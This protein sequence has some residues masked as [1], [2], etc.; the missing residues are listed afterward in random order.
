MAALALGAAPAYA[1]DTFS[2]PVYL[3]DNG[4]TPLS[5]GQIIESLGTLDIFFGDDIKL[6]DSKFPPNYSYIN[7]IE[8]YLSI[9]FN[10]NELVTQNNFPN[11][12]PSSGAFFYATLEETNE[13][14]GG[15][16][17]FDTDVLRI[18]FPSDM[19]FGFGSPALCAG[20]GA[21]VFT[22]REGAVTTTTGQVN[23]EIKLVLY[24][25]S[26][27]GS[28]N[29]EHP[30][31][32]TPS[33]EEGQKP[34]FDYGKCS[35]SLTWEGVNSIEINQNAVNLPFVQREDPNNDDK[36]GD[37]I[38]VLGFMSTNGA[39]LKFDFSTLPSGNYVLAVP[40]SSVFINGEYLNWET[41]LNFVIKDTPA[42]T[43]PPAVVS[44]N[45][46]AAYETL[47]AVYVTWMEAP[48]ALNPN[49]TQKVTVALDG[50]LL[51]VEPKV[52]LSFTGGNVKEGIDGNQLTID[53][54]GINPETGAYTITVPAGYVL[55]SDLN[56]NGS[57]PN[58]KVIAE[59]VVE[60][61]LPTEPI[62]LTN[63]TWSL[64]ANTEITADSDPVT[65]TWGDYELSLSF[66]Q[67]VIAY[68]V[69]TDNAI[70]LIH[71]ELLNLSTDKTAIELLLN[72]LPEGTYNVVIPSHYV[73]MEN[74][75]LFNGETSRIFTVSGTTGVAAIGAG[76]GS[77]KVCN[78]QGVEVMNT[79]DATQLR[80]LKKGIYI[81]NGRK[82]AVD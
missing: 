67:E 24:K 42:P 45:Q 3:T 50:N 51:T 14:T 21:L 12:G 2:S 64:P 58:E 10:G 29:T 8:D 15:T 35:L 39:S 4:Y 31:V 57:L 62:E 38:P 9:T 23:P 79:S 63:A 48:L 44:P 72:E 16:N 49:C 70:E 56:G 40:Q 80:S 54:S 69:N 34:T 25:M 13:Q 7:P 71:S 5:N 52:S 43:L 73:T 61:N 37:H 76:N 18:T 32:W 46:E 33:A 47:D 78:L 75:M 11:T 17:V 59:Y 65:V 27:F 36:Y 74:G 28:E 53:L 81:I 55:V 26:L 66:E 20:S 30:A 60:L 22:I 82:V 77:Y 41:T 68:N 1:A 19:W 6:K